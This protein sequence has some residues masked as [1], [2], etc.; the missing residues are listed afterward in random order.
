MANREETN[1]SRGI[2]LSFG[3]RS[4]L[5]IRLSSVGPIVLCKNTL[6]PKEGAVMLSLNLVWVSKNP[7]RQGQKS[8]ACSSQTFLKP[9]R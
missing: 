7:W 4:Y 3:Y 6:P 9:P 8:Q 5:I 1:M 2:Y